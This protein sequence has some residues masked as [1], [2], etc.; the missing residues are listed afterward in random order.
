MDEPLSAM[1]PYRR[2]LQPGVLDL[3]GNGVLAAY[4][5][6]GPPPETSDD[7]ELANRVQLLGRG[8]GLLNT[9]DTVQIIFHRLEAPEPSALQFEHE[10]AQVVHNELRAL[11]KSQEHWVTFA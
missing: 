10:A 3:A 2:P 4:C 7:D 9:G 6:V 8:L 5:M 11:W 1:L